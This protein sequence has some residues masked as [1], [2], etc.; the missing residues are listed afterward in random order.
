MA[1]NVDDQIETHAKEG[2]QLAKLGE[3]TMH[4]LKGIAV[5]AIFWIGVIFSLYQIYT[6]AYSPLSSLVMRSLHVGFLLLLA[7]LLHRAT[8]NT[9]RSSVPWYDWILAGTAFALSF[10]HWIF[11]VEI[12]TRQGDPPETDFW[13]GVVVLV[14]LFEAARRIVGLALPL[15]CLAFIAYAYFGR[16][17]PAPFIHRGYDEVRIVGELYLGFEGIYGIPTLVSSTYA[18]GHTRGGLAKVSVITSGLM[19]TINGSGVANVVTT[20]QFTIPL[21]M[22]FG[23]RPAFAGAVEATSSMGGQIMPPV[24]GAVAFI[25]AETIDMPYVQICLAAIIP[26]LLYYATAFWMVHLEAGRAGLRGIPKDERPDPIAAI[27]KKWHLLL[28]LAALV[29]LLF[30]GYTPLFA[31]TV[32]L[33]LTV[34]F[35]LGASNAGR[36]GAFPLRAAFWVVIAVASAALFEVSGITGLFVVIGV[37]IGACLLAAGTRATLNMC[38]NAL[39]DGAR[40]ALGVGIACAL[41]GVIIGV[42]TLTGLAGTFARI[43]L[44]LAGGSLFLTLLMTMV[45]CLILGMGIPTIP[46]YIITSTM[47]APILLQMGVPLIVSHMF[48][49]YFGIMADL[50]PPVALAAFAASAIARENAMRI[51]VIATRIAVAGYVVPFMAVYDPA[52]MMQTDNPLAVIYMVLKAGTGITLW[53]AAV[54]GYFLAP[55]N[56]LERIWAFGGAAFL[57][58]ALPLT[59]EIGFAASAA[60]VIWHWLRVKRTPAGARAR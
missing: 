43:V 42:M 41:V 50:T 47:A 33:A 26:A 25:M 32:G 31:G 48:V 27:K 57:V 5:P 6:A 10:Y 38:V 35:I 21:M 30:S 56:P 40:Q 7:F 17:I 18:V 55:I 12:I 51:A 20:G 3:T 16:S 58:A 54:T 53:G 15:I 45:I 1:M 46:N 60:F 24:M 36:F 14:L 39:S 4:G 59:D 19:G 22:R 37:L 28:P 23:Y 52:L 11:E 49:F 13:V 44:D 34:I 9:D 2:E 8:R 29:Y